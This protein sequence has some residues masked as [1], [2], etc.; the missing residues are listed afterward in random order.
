[1]RCGIWGELSGIAVL[2]LSHGP[3]ARQNQSGVRA[4]SVTKAGQSATVA[5]SQ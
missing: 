1:L 5:H 2:R 4:A 3:S